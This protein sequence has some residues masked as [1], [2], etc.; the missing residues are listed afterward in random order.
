MARCA[1]NLQGVK[2]VS[3]ENMNI[4]D[5]LHYTKLFITKSAVAKIE[6]VL[7]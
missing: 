7:A 2:S 5:L 4:F 1:R 6:E 3:T